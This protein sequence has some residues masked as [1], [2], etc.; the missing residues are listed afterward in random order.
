MEA[1]TAREWQGV[2]AHCL[3]ALRRMAISS[4]V[5]ANTIT[6]VTREYPCHALRAP[7]IAARQAGLTARYS[8]MRWQATPILEFDRSGCEAH[9]GLGSC[10]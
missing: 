4:E 7:V 8:G 9:R 1:T 10:F 3:H 5:I 2:H 6:V